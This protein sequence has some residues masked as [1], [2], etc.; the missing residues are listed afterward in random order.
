MTPA[1]AAAQQLLDSAG[2]SREQQVLDYPVWLDRGDT[3]SIELVAF[4]RNSPRED[5]HCDRGV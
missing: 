4:A 1:I 3:A 2:Y 5:D